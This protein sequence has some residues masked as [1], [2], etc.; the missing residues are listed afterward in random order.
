MGKRIRLLIVLGSVTAPGRLRRALESAIDRSAGED[1]IDA[2]LVDLA[3]YRLELV[4]REGEPDDDRAELIARIADADAVVFATPVYRGSFTGALKNLLDATPVEALE[5]KP[6]GIVAMGA[7][8]HHFLGAERHLRDV[9]AFFGALLAPVAVYLTSADF[10][11]GEPTARASAA[12][13]E[14]VGGVSSIALAL[15][16]AW[17][18]GPE[19]LAARKVPVVQSS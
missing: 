13:G 9:L 8:Q 16:A 15:P 19:P 2:E 4:G 14:L 10:E 5:S 6:V 3:D 17:K 12:L 18:L 1:W 7:S 11:E